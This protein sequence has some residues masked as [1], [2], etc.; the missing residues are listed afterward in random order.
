MV[1]TQ[2][3]ALS[4]RKML[5]SIKHAYATKERRDN[6]FLRSSHTSNTTPAKNATVPIRLFV[7]KN[8]P[9]I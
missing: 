6:P 7:V 5:L 9:S 3:S 8:N 4:D 1:S 2:K